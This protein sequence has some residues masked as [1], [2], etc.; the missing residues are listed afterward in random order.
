MINFLK[1][2]AFY[3]LIAVVVLYFIGRYLYAQP[4]FINGEAAPDFKVA[5]RDGT[6]FQLSQ[7]KGSYVL[8]DFW[9]S[10]CGPCIQEVPALKRLHDGFHNVPFSDAK[11]FEIV[12]VGIETDKSRWENAINA[13]QMNWQ[14]H[15]S[16]LQNLNSPLAKQF[17]VRVIPT[18]FLLNTEGVI[19]GVNQSAEEIEK[20]LKSKMK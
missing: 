14:Y 17:G 5:L 16:D 13:L 8:L 7:L 4:K 18:K 9:G 1:N 2:N 15:T 10:W 3:I 19:I 11:G 20:F 6:P 12:S